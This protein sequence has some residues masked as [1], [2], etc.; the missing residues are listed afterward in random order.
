MLHVHQPNV[1]QGHALAGRGRGVARGNTQRGAGLR[2]SSPRFRR[3]VGWMA[4]VLAL[5][6]PRACYAQCDGAVLQHLLR[7][8]GLSAE[9]SDEVDKYWDA[10]FS[11]TSQNELRPLRYRLLVRVPETSWWPDIVSW[12]NASLRRDDVQAIQQRLKRHRELHS[13]CA[14]VVRDCEQVAA[15]IQLRQCL[16]ALLD[17]RPSRGKSTRAARLR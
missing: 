1:V 12:L 5:G 17:S 9:K 6:T 8:P 7:L 4:V 13:A 2:D 15:N 11:L 16:A 14:A 3:A 10:W